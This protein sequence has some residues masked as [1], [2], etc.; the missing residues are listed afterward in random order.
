[1]KEFKKSQ[2]T[3]IGMMIL[4]V[5]LLCPTFG[6]WSI[7]MVIQWVNYQSNS[8]VLTKDGVVIKTGVFAKQINEIKYS[9]INSISVSKKW[10][11]NIGDIV[12]FA[13]NDV[14]GI[15]FKDVDNPF[16]VKG[17]IDKMLGSH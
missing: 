12:I 5:I 7:V 11:A 14:T 8:L 4:G 13:G 2:R 9:K 16:E 17:E 3:F 10:W 6:L 1:M 15:A